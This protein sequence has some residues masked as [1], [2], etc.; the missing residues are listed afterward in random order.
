MRQLPIPY[1]EVMVKSLL[2]NLKQ[3]TRRTKG[4]ELVN[5]NPDDWE[6]VHILNLP[7]ENRY[8]V[9]F[10]NTKT[11]KYGTLMIPFS[12]GDQLWVKETYTTLVPEHFVEPLKTKY[13]Y[14]A[15]CDAESE[16]TR[17]EYVAQG[18]PYKWITGRYMPK[19]AARIWLEVTDIKCE[20]LQSIS[21]KDCI[22]EGILP[23]N[24]SAA[25][26]AEQGQRYFDYSKPKQHFV[27]GL[28]PF[29]SFNSLWCRINGGDSWEAN[30]WVF[31]YTFKQIEPPT[32]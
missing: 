5:Q 8:M 7:L 1:A 20:R 12:I 10:R 17:R 4:L 30:P 27:D 24:M 32:G 11:G 26:L 19:A 18:Y 22:A 13:V 14:K 6:F 9:E 2:Q 28:D 3:M 21:H 16:Q 23:L 25:Q 29:W 15:D 31:A